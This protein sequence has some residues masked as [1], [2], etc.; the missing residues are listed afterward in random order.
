[1]AAV[2]QPRH[3]VTNTIV[4]RKR[5]SKSRPPKAEIQRHSS[6]YL[7]R[8]IPVELQITPPTLNEFLMI[9]LGVVRNRDVFEQ[10]IGHDVA[11]VPLRRGNRVELITADIG[12][13]LLVATKESA[14]FDVVITDDF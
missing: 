8:V 5:R 1:M 10:H 12:F 11:G 9:N 14:D 7:P 13:V 3:P 2:V 4:V 6:A